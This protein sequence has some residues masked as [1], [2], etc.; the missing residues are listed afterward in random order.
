MPQND[1][2]TVDAATEPWFWANESDY[3]ALPTTPLEFLAGETT[4]TVEVTVHGDTE[5]E[6]DYEA[7]LLELSNASAGVDVGYENGTSQTYEG[8][9]YRTTGSP[10]VGREYQPAAFRVADVGSYR[11]RFSAGA[12]TFEYS[13]DGRGGTLALQRQLF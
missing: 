13:V 2:A 7:F 9:I 1:L 8:R 10:W 6:G 11:L 12:A 3:D 5:D 4:K